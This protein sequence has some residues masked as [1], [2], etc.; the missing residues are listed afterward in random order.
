M[1]Y[2]SDITNHL[3]DSVEELNEAEEQVR[4]RDAEKNMLKAE[5]DRLHENVHKANAEYEAALREYCEKYGTYTYT[6]TSN[7]DKPFD[8]K[9]L[10][11]IWN[12]LF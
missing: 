6:H 9:T 10:E 8:Y 12:S 11:K 3:Y 5:V 4:N 7:S 2:Y 1:K